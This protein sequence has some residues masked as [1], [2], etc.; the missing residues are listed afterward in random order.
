MAICKSYIKNPDSLRFQKEL[1]ARTFGRHYTVLSRLMQC[2][3]QIRETAPQ[4]VIEAK[5]K[6]TDLVKVWK[7][8]QVEILDFLNNVS[9]KGEL[10]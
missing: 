3:C 9:M 1:F 8:A 5:Q 10:K 2:I 7:L 4:W 6:A